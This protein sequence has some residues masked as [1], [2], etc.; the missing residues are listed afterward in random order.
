MTT[1]PDTISFY[2]TSTLPTEE[3]LEAMQLARLGD[4]VY[5][6]DPTVNALEETAAEMLGKEAGIFMPS[7][8]MSNLVAVMVHTR[9]GDEV[10][11]E[12]GAHIMYYE[13]GGISAVAGVMPL[14]IEADRGILRAALVEPR[15]R[16]PNQHYP[17]TSLLCV[18][19]THN[20]AGG[21]ITPPTVMHELRELCDRWGLRLHVDGARIFNAAVALGISARDLVADA[22]SVWFALS[23]G[24]SAPVGSVLLGTRDFVDEARRKRKMLGGSMR[25]A[26]VL[27]A[28]G[29]VAL[30]HGVDRL[31]EDHARARALARRLATIPGLGVEPEQV[32][33]NMV[34]V[35]TH[36]TGLQADQ[37]VAELKRRGIRAS[38][39]PPYTV[40]FVTHRHIGD[41]QIE[42]LI[43]ALREIVARAA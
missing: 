23:K 18:E 26:G 19:N 10:V 28:A 3:M 30:Q 31:A 42:A 22:D 37:L 4:D 8:T 34:L 14:A 17:R 25:Q 43:A 13:T 40:R 38:S 9:H 15:L 11:V 6:E 36:N 7:G 27:A 16:R 5:H 29:L 32:E 35:D 24:L 12:P 39:R 21:S 2:D 41:A 1:P 33:T 20:R